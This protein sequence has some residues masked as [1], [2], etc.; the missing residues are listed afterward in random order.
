MS[1]ANRRDQT[2]YKMTGSGNDFIFVDGRE[3]PVDRWTV[4]DIQAVCARRIGVGADG[5]VVLEPGSGP[6][7]VRFHFFNSDGSRGAM[8]GNAALCATRLAALLELAPTGGMILETD[9]GEVRTR[10]L[11]DAPHRAELTLPPVVRLNHPN[12]PL[13]PG[14]QAIG[15]AVVGVDHV[16][17]LVDDLERIPM[18]V[19]GPVLRQHPALGPA[20]ANV[21]FVA[22]GPEGWAMRT[23]ER[24]VEGETLACGTGAVACGVYLAS[25]RLVTLPWHVRSRSGVSLT[26]SATMSPE[27][28]AIAADPRLAGEGRLVYQARLVS[29]AP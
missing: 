13:D 19:R 15:F 26:V 3:Q 12:I 1:V 4:A 5:L 28:V 17:V 10:C 22:P 16:V 20:G 8:C 29:V 18:E 25:R 2:I 6:G 24:G 23:W 21:N 14:E 9:A 7:R 11:D 27:G